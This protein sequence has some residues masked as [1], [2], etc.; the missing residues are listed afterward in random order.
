MSA[1]T[2]TTRLARTMNAATVYR[3]LR[4]L[5]RAQLVRR[6]NLEH[7]HAHFELTEAGDHHHLVCTQC[8][9]TEDVTCTGI[10][11]FADQVLAKSRSFIAV[12][13]HAFEL[14]GRCRAC[15]T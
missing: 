9:R 13:R 2:L 8:G 11:E 4:S 7:D 14:F 3:T 5:E 12:D 10:E 6:V 15:A 1:S